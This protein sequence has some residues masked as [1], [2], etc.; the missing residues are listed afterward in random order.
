MQIHELNNFTG[1]L[2]AGTYLAI[3]NGTDT[4]RISSQNILAAT[5]A[6][7]DN[8]EADTTSIG[9]DV[10]ELITS[11]TNLRTHKVAQPLDE[12]DQPTDG[13]NGQLLRTKGNGATE[14]VDE[15]L[16]T[17]EQTAQAVSDWLDEHPEATTTVEDGAITFSKMG[18]GMNNC[19]VVKNITGLKASVAPYVY[20]INND[21]KVSDIQSDHGEY[22]DDEPFSVNRGGCWY[23]THSNNLGGTERTEIYGGYLRNNGDVMFAMPDQGDRNVS[24]KE[25][26]SMFDTFASYFSAYDLIYGANGTMF[27]AD[28][29]ADENGKYNIDCTTLVSAVI[30]GIKKENSRY[31]LGNSATNIT[32]TYS[33]VS[34]PSTRGEHLIYLNE[35]VEYFAENKQLFTLHKPDESHKA[36]EYN[37]LQVGDILFSCSPE[38]VGVEQARWESYYAVDHCVIVLAVYPE[39]G[40][41]LI[42]EGGGSGAAR[43]GHSV[44]YNSDF[45]WLDDD[46]TTS[47]LKAVKVDTVNIYDYIGT[48]YKVF[49]RPTYGQNRKASNISGYFRTYG[50]QTHTEANSSKQLAYIVPSSKMTRNNGFT[51]TVKGILPK[52]EDEGAYMHSLVR[53]Q[54]NNNVAKT[55]R[56]DFGY[57]IQGDGKTISFPLFLPDTDTIAAINSIAIYSNNGAETGQTY[58]VDEMAICNGADFFANGSKPLEFTKDSNFPNTVYNF[59]YLKDGKAHIYLTF[60]ASGTSGTITLGKFS[61]L[62]NNKTINASRFFVGNIGG[63]NLAT[64]GIDTNGNASYYTSSTSTSQARFMF[65]LD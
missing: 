59:S 52:Y 47:I 31:E 27:M 28:C 11:V 46:P 1:T 30:Q 61:D 25:L 56:Y 57:H 4:G 54:D 45:G 50:N 34:L 20:V 17:D 62:I 33:A 21:S 24:T 63:V 26:S 43:F 55:I 29:V 6:R 10:S 48:K 42:G 3:D 7:I 60:N 41:I 37:G 35:L 39:E 15:G 8:I 14:W 13:I 16:P 53:Y 65:E 38:A 23:W 19:Q 2:G 36:V 5:E 22:F 18:I 40:T 51:I 64:L 44:L 49:A 9:E 58:R 12:N 32:S